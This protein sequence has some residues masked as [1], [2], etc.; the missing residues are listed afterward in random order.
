MANTNTEKKLTKGIMV[1][2]V[3]A[4]CLC[5]TTFALVWANL[6]VENSLFHTGSVS[7]NL[8]D[9]EAVIHENEFLFEPGMLVEKEFFIENDSTCAIYYKLYL[10]D[11]VGG[12]ADVLEIKILDGDKVLYQ[13]VAKDLTKDEV[14]AADD[15]LQIKEKRNLKIT[16]Y[17][18]QNTGN[19]GQGLDLSFTICADATQTKNNPNR[20]FD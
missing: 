8:N 11:V 14:I 17:Y 10:D 18:P 16:F 9:G 15:M 20:L 2:I 12:L 19:D 7:I 1:I 3:L 5:I 4:C 6:T 13:G